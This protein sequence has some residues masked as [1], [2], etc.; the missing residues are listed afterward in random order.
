[1]RSE[2]APVV[3]IAAMQKSIRLKN[4]FSYGP[5]GIEIP[6]GALNVLGAAVI[7]C[8]VLLVSRSE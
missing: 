2:R 7:L 1:M 4:F 8:G 5:E 6:M 3:K